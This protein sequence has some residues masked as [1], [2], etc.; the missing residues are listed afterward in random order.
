[1]LAA[2]PTDDV[3]SILVIDD[4]PDNRMLLDALLSR[5]GYRVLTAEDGEQGLRVLE[6]E[7]PALILLDYSMPGLSGPEVALRIRGQPRTAATPIILL[8]ASTATDHIDEAFAAGADDYVTKPFDRRILTARIES[9][10]RAAEDRQRARGSAD[11]QQQRDRMLSDLQDAARVQREQITPLPIN[12]AFGTISGAVV[13]CHHIGGDS[14]QVFFD[15]ERTTAVII[16]VSGH[17]AAAA[18]VASAV[19]TELRGYVATHSLAD[20][21]AMINRQIANRWK[22]HYACIAAIQITKHGAAMINAGLP[23]IC[24]VR[25][26]RIIATVEGSGA[27]PGLLPSSVYEAT[28]VDFRVG[29]RLIAISDGL[30][31]PLSGVADDV[32]ACLDGLAL[33]TRE[34]AQSSDLLAASVSALFGGKELEDDATLLLVDRHC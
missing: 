17:G 28:E 21:F 27:P 3:R 18:L 7:S 20:C 30:T 23:P 34:G 16:D 5:A 29:D 13:P 14:L 32:Q 2:L 10:I 11:L 19:V 33:L 22:L 24:H 12:Y 1:M 9:M 4:G 8:T 26:G 25:D 31:E 6:H 15:N